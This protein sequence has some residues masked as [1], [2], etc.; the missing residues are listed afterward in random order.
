M[1]IA[2]VCVCVCAPEC[3]CVCGCVCVCV[4]T[5]IGGTSAQC[6][7]R[8]ANIDSCVSTMADPRQ[9]CSA[10]YGFNFDCVRQLTS[11]P[12]LLTSYSPAVTAAAPVLQNSCWLFNEAD[13]YSTMA[14]AMTCMK[15]FGCVVLR[16]LCA[17]PCASLFSMRLLR[18]TCCSCCL[19]LASS[20]V[21]TWAASPVETYA[22]C[23]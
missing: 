20:G 11:N 19:S 1:C 15:F 22:Y 5:C 13:C 3:G 6:N 21:T 8:L 2:C 4:L 10:A 18:V 14:A 16:W 17:C 12:D 23:C 7:A 9:C